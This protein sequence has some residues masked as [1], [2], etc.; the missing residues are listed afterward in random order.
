MPIDYSH[1]LG[2]APVTG[3]ERGQKFF[4]DALD[5]VLQRRQEM[6]ARRMQ[7][8]AQ[9]EQS[10][11]QRDLTQGYYDQQEVAG[12]EQR[13]ETNRRNLVTEGQTDVRDRNSLATSRSTMYGQAATHAAAGRD[14]VAARMEA[15]FPGGQPQGAQQRPVPAGPMASPLDARPP[16]GRP[17]PAPPVDQST[18]GVTPMA[19]AGMEPGPLPPL[20]PTFTGDGPLPPQQGGP[21]QP[22]QRPPQGPIADPLDASVQGL[23]WKA[24]GPQ[25]LV[26]ETLDNPQLN[27][28]LRRTLESDRAG[29]GKREDVAALLN[30]ER[31]RESHERNAMIAGGRTTARGDQ[32]AS[33]RVAAAADSLLNSVYRRTDYGQESEKFKSTSKM[34]ADFQSGSPALQK[35]AAGLWAKL[36]SG[37][38]VV[39]ESERNE[40]VN[41][42]GG[43][44]EQIKKTIL[45]WISDGEIPED[46]LGFF[47]EAIQRFEIPRQRKRLAVIDGIVRGAYSRHPLPEMREY[48]DWAA[49]QAISK[50]TAPPPTPGGDVPATREDIDWIINGDDEDR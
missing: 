48:A 29:F 41:S 37:P 3:A 46:Q 26:D 36:A 19:G 40:F 50:A 6:E 18:P 31:N 5:A 9:A 22:Q 17:I 28:R 34:L 2:P 21:P 44:D 32:T 24:M 14:D 43:I 10:R 42:I 30:A 13:T 27:A 47:V 4:G 11:L 45:K 35:T 49:E 16:P 12:N 33:I 23:N 39:T 1:I 8:E 20:D 7:L 38:G 25:A 15:Q